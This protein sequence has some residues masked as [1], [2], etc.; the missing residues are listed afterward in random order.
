MKGAIVCLLIIL[1][2]YAILQF[3]RATASTPSSAIEGN[4]TLHLK[5]SGS[6][7]YAEV[8]ASNINVTFLPN[9]IYSLKVSVFVV[10]GGVGDPFSITFGMS[11]LPYANY[12]FGVRFTGSSSS[13]PNQVL[14]GNF[15]TGPANWKPGTWYDLEFRLL[16][17]STS[18]YMNGTQI[19]GSF[20]NMVSG[21]TLEGYSLSSSPTGEIYADAISVSE[22]N[23]VRYFDG[24]ENGLSNLQV[25]RSGSAIVDTAYFGQGVGLS[26][27]VISLVPGVCC[28]ELFE[29]TM[30]SNF[31]IDGTIENATSL[32]AVTS[33]MI[34][35]EVSYDHGNSYS[36]IG[37]AP[38][39]Q[40]GNFSVYWKPSKVGSA[41]LQA[42]YSGNCCL[43]GDITTVNGYTSPAHR[44]S[45]DL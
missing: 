32:R 23:S 19:G 7:G 22:D 18:F 33:A 24:F 10:S 2:S 44:F 4:Y 8:Q 16:N 31:R 45:S 21:G 25:L 43:L 26:A 11:S 14:F 37:S 17:G 29:A 28:G 30:G 13:P 38:S 15:G 3:P 41:I 9:K 12:N 34:T 20:S 6:G 42:V 36:P 39:D 5:T 35:V 27:T 40:Y 1:T